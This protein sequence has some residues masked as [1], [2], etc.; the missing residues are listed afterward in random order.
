MGRLQG[1]VSM[2]VPCYNKESYIGA[3]LDSVLAQK[4]DNIE[5]ILVNDGSTDGTRGVII[6]YLPK[7]EKRGYGVKLIDQENGGCCKAVHTGLVNMTGDYYC[8]VDC[9]DAITPEYVSAMAGFLDENDDYEWAACS[10]RPV[11]LLDDVTTIGAVPKCPYPQDTDNLIEKWIL[12]QTITTVWIYMVRIRYVD[13]CR[14]VENWNTARNRTYEPLVGIPLMNGGGKLKYFHEGF[15]RYTQTSR[16]LF[17][18]EKY[19]DI[20][21]YYDDYRA[22]YAWSIARLAAD[23]N[24]KRRLTDLVD[25]AYTRELFAQLHAIKDK[26]RH[27]D[28][29][30]ADLIEKINRHKPNMRITFGLA[31]QLGFMTIYNMACFAITGSPFA[32]PKRVIGYGV[33]GKYGRKLLPH[34]MGTAYEPYVLWDKNGD[35]ERVRRPDFDDL[36][37]TDLIIVFPKDR[38]VVE[39][40]KEELGNAPARIVYPEEEELLRSLLAVPDFELGGLPMTDAVKHYKTGYVSGSFDMFHVGHLNLLRRARECCGHLIVGVLSDACILAGKKKAP[41]IP[42]EDRLEIVRSCKYVDEV[43]VTTDDLL[44]KVTAWHKYH[45]D[46]MF[47]GDDHKDDGWAWEEPELNRLGVELV[48]FPYTQKVSSTRLRSVLENNF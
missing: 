33:L 3:M 40:I 46:A 39:D 6:D 19:E 4:W 43:D 47:T 12:R 45:F 20:T 28:Q 25:L 35:G 10:Y 38:K 16:D 9:D 21:H 48:F 18:F 8:L 36:S 44:N 1:K 11:T 29:L 26:E 13:R 14:M 7:F 23:E 17:V 22:Q 34:Y 24:R 37:E 27:A 41:V 5:L 2:V 30:C 31:K 32:S 15:Y 42:L